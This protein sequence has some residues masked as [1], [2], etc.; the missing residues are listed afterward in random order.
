MA[1]LTT[2]T[3]PSLPTWILNIITVIPLSILVILLL[4]KWHKLWNQSLTC[5]P[6][7][8]YQHIGIIMAY[9]YY[10]LM[11]INEL[12]LFRSITCV[13][14][15]IPLSPPWELVSLLGHSHRMCVCCNILQPKNELTLSP[16]PTRSISSHPLLCFPSEKL[17]RPVIHVW[18]LPPSSPCSLLSP[19]P[20]RLVSLAL[21]PKPLALLSPLDAWAL[22][23]RLL[24]GCFPFVSGPV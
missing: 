20:P 22:P 10:N 2:C 11:L 12:S 9:D 4:L 1:L 3:Q 5:S 8:V 24:V 23:S 21:P 19:F 18:C 7:R 15:S 17:S 14:D 16:E 13:L 6:H